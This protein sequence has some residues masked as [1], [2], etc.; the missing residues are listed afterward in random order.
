[1]TFHRP[2]LGCTRAE[3]RDHLTARGLTWVEDPSNEDPV[4]DR[5]RARQALRALGPLDSTRK[6]SPAPRVT[7]ARPRTW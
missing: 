3:L 7:Y 6:R 2:T 4:Y 1:V 5:A